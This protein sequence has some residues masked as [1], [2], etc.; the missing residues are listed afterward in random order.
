MYLRYRNSY[1]EYG[2]SSDTVR[3]TYSRIKN[4]I[5][6]HGDFTV[7][8]NII[9]KTRVEY[10][11]SR[12]KE[13]KNGFMMYQDFIYRSSDSRFTTSFRYAWFNTDSYNERFYAYE[14][15]LLYTFSV[16]AY[17]YK[18]NR[19]YLLSSYKISETVTVWLRIANT[20]FSD[21]D[22]I[23][24]GGEEIKGNNK[25]DVKAQVVIKFRKSNP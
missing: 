22:T 8:K 1:R 19:V 7:S 3:Q 23:G 14:N 24:S 9:L 13:N 10:I 17:Y 6:W 15:D 11:Y 20:F 21:H 5:R 2:E 12:D 25:T 18:G 4:N 16:P